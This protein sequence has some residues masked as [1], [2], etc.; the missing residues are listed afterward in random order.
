MKN[1][2]KQIKFYKKYLRLFLQSKMYAML[3]HGPFQKPVA[4]PKAQYNTD[5]PYGLN[6]V[7]QALRSGFV[8]QF[9]EAACSVASIATVL[10]AA[11]SLCDLKSDFKVITQEEILLK[12]DAV[13]WAARISP[14]GYQNKRGLP[15]DKLG[16][17]TKSA[18]NA[19]DIPYAS[20]VTVPL[21]DHALNINELKKKLFERLAGFGRNSHCFLIA[22]F[23]QGIFLK[24][25][26]L[27]H[28]SPIGCVDMAKEMI[29]VLDVDP[30]VPEPYW[31]SFDTFF[32]GLAWTYNGILRKYGYFG[33]GYIW[34]EMK[35]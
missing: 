8:T 1:L 20:I 2:L 19:Y 6:P 10:N 18:L 13:N 30:H 22:H 14:E 32:K 29:L 9:N 28:I 27:P 35:K 25:L 12:V 33:G 11:K 24:G 21:A 4:T 23:N 5:T 7:F 15:I 17:V 34:I 31:V 26:H 16:I 3:N